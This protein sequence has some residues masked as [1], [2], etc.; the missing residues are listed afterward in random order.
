YLH[1]QGRLVNTAGNPLTGPY[2]VLF[3]IYDAPSGPTL[4]WSETQSVTPDNGIFAASLGSVTPL[5][6]SVFSSDSRYL[7]VKVGADNPMTP[8]TQLLS[9]PYAITAGNLGSPASVVT[10]STHVIMS[11]SQLRLGNFASAPA[12]VAGPGAIYFN[13]TDNLLYYYKDTGWTAL[14]ADGSSPWGGGGTGSVTLSTTSDKVGVGKA[15]AEKLDVA[16]NIKADYGVTASTGVFSGVV[17]AAGFSGSGSGLTGVIT[18]TAALQSQI[19][20]IAVDTGT[21]TSGKVPYTGAAGAVNLGANG[22]TASSGTFTATGQ[23]SVETSSGINI[24]AGLL[25]VAKSTATLQGNAIMVSTG[26]IPMMMQSGTGLLNVDGVQSITFTPPFRAGTTPIVMLT[27]VQAADLTPAMWAS[28]VVSTGFTA[29]GDSGW[30][31]SWLAV[32]V[33]P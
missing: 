31:Y 11:A 17:T 9:V 10:V 29:N 27:Y 2:S 30:K 16:G 26:P 21:L 18:S 6:D 28:V 8:R 5:P 3:S 33:T 4:I 23:Y 15:P 22:I 13:S 32:G 7:E 25:V 1:Y 14:V 24:K 12:T 19:N 20:S